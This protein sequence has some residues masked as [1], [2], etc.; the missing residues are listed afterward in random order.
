MSCH[1]RHAIPGHNPEFLDKLNR[2]TSSY[3]QLTATLAVLVPTNV[4]RKPCEELK[5]P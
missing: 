2:N 3:E 4:P 1:N 5:V